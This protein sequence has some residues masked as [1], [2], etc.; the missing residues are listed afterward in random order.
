MEHSFLGSASILIKTNKN[1]TQ[2]NQTGDSKMTYFWL[3]NFNV[4]RSHLTKN[5]GDM[6]TI[7]G[8]RVRITST[9]NIIDE[10]ITEDNCCHI[11]YTKHLKQIKDNKKYSN[12][13]PGISKWR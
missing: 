7:C 5:I 10:E 1:Y 9:I 3:R 12:H 13:F 6:T 4:G 11:C 8:T 2:T